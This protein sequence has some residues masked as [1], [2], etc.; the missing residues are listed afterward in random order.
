[1][2]ASDKKK[3]RKEASAQLLTEKQ[4]QQQKEAKKLKA[5]TIAFV[6][7]MVLVVCITLA[8]LGVRAVNNSGVFQNNTIAANVGEN[9]L[10]SVELSYFFTDE[11]NAYYNEWYQTYST[12]TDT[13]LQMLGWD[14]SK[15]LDEQFQ[16]EETNTT[17]AQYFLDAALDQAKNDYALAAKAKEE[18]FELPAEDQTTL[19]NLLGNIETY[20]TLYGYRNAKQY[21]RAMYGYGSTPESYGE[22]YERSLL[23]S[24][25]AAAHHEGLTYENSKI[26]DYEADKMAEFN[27]YTYTSAYMSYTYFQQGGTKDE[28]GN[29]TYS[30]EENAAARESMKAAAD[31]LATATTDDELEAMV[32]EIAVKDGSSISVTKNENLLYSGVSSSIREWLSSTD[33]K[34]GD[35]TAIA[36]VSTTTNEDGTE[37]EL[38]NGYYVVIFHGVNDNATAMGNVRHLLVKFEGG[39]EDE[40]TGEVTYSEAEKAAAKEEAEGYL[41][42]WQ[43]GDATE[44]SFIALVKAHSDDSSASEGGLFEDI[45]RD[46]SYVDNF[47]NWS[48][49][50]ARKAGDVAVIETEYGYHVMYFVGNSELTYRDYMI[51]SEMRDSD[52]EAWYDAIVDAVTASLADTSKMRLDV[53]LS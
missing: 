28:N 7:A 32:K 19:T 42:S 29:I 16:N 2:S 50:A 25:Y 37:T 43:E 40:E 21:L 31:K 6:T 34:D 23:A 53:V 22:Y 17:W 8:V 10:S 27:S 51:T 12:Y 45:H 48:I 30:E 4:L 47:L 20:A 26:R 9:A 38:T 3:L 44:E 11:I 33:R 15:P 18:G 49:D 1:M 52:H 14:T 36:N 35:I 5:Y 46:S 39:T 24:A 41:K 13:Y